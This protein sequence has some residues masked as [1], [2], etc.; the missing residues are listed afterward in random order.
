MK[1]RD[2]DAAADAMRA[3][4][5]DLERAK[6]EGEERAVANADRMALTGQP[7]ATFVD[8]FTAGW[9]ADA[10]TRAAATLRAAI[11]IYLTPKPARRSGPRMRR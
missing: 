8:H 3:I 2:R 9:V 10:T 6:R 7:R 1:N 5:L 4:A 11:D